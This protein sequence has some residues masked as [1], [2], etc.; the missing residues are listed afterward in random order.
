MSILQIERRRRLRKPKLLI[1]FSILILLLPV[2]NYIG[3]SMKYDFPWYLP[4]HLIQ[5]ANLPEWILLISSFLSGLGL[6]F[7]KRWGWWLFILSSFTFILYNSYGFLTIPNSATKG[8]LIQT[9]IVTFAL[10]Y[11]LQRDIFIP[12]LK[13]YTRGWRLLRRYPIVINININD[14]IFKTENISLGGIFIKANECNFKINSEVAV[15][16]ELAKEGFW[17]KAGIASITPGYG[18]AIAF[19]NTDTLFRDRLKKSIM[20]FE[21][22]KIES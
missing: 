12:Y 14:T 6:I 8:P 19:R 1:S 4:Y 21:K 18:F 22:K 13:L 5:Y 15:Y 7:I 17:T 10:A 11:F 9:F 16:F 20:I 2:S 3:M